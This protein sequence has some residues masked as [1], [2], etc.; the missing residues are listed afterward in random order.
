[1]YAE[2]KL[3]ERIRSTA[4][5]QLWKPAAIERG[6]EHEWWWDTRVGGSVHDI[7]DKGLG[8]LNL[9]RDVVPHSVPV[10]GWGKHRGFQC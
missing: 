7:E 10:R 8:A 9:T 1:M 5:G 6:A 4:S 2:E 3:P